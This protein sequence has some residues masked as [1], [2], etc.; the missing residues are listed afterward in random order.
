MGIEPVVRIGHAGA[1]FRHAPKHTKRSSNSTA[2]P[3]CA[4]GAFYQAP[5]LGSTVESTT[6]LN[7]VWQPS[8]DCLQPVPTYVDI[9]LDNP[10]ASSPRLHMWQAVPY[11]KGNYTINMQPGWWN[12]SSSATLQI[13]IVSTGTQ[14]FLST[15]PAGP[16]FTATTSSNG[17]ATSGALSN[18]ATTVVT[19]TTLAGVSSHKLTGGQKAA[20]VLLPLL[21]VI[22]LALAYVKISR[23][24]GAAKRTEWSEKLDKR[25]STISTDWK[26][27]TAAGASEAVR[28]SIARN[29]TAFSFGFGAIRTGNVEGDPVVMG[30]KPLPIP[31]S[32]LDVSEKDQP[33]TSLGTGVGVRRPRPSNASAPPDRASRAVSFADAAHPRPSMS[34]AYSRSSRAFH[35][36][37]TYGD[38]EAEEAPPVP[39]LPSPSRIS[40]YG[41][42]TPRKS[43]GSNNNNGN[44]VASIY[45]HHNGSAWSS[46][47]RVIGVDGGYGARSVSPTGRVHTINY[48]S[49]ASMGA[50]GDNNGFAYGESTGE[51]SYFSPVTPTVNAFNTVYAEDPSAD[52]A[53]GATTFDAPPEMTSPRQTAGPLTL[54]PEDI[55]RRMTATHGANGEGAWRQSVDEVFGA[56]SMMRTGGSPE[57]EEDNAGDYLFAPMP[58]TVFAYPGTPAASSFNSTAPLATTPTSPFAM[59]MS[60]EPMASSPDAMLRSY[61]AKH[62]SAAGAP[63]PLSHSTGGAEVVSSLHNTGMRVLYDGAP[64]QP[65]PLRKTTL[66]RAGKGARVSK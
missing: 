59:P 49:A 2:D 39:A 55:R 38:L 45:T 11:A 51:G 8:L 12:S 60:T 54:T 37:S 53:Y 44:R 10:G 28:Q 43:T 15:L 61:A 52:S 5:S 7:V 42:A 14:P 9:Y 6:P 21:F 62:A 40:A 4:T 35:V 48:P 22:L 64:S 30:E 33:R 19:T 26:S 13:M 47:E 57:A 24:R 16:V 1:P 29:S 46:G 27:I 50:S 23:A 20:A 17:T 31:R 32:S 41:E 63:S 25:M 34:S 56:L 36:G 18:Q 66:I 58:E 3:S 65:A